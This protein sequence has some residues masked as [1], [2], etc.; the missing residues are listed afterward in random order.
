MRNLTLGGIA[1]ILLMSGCAL[2]QTSG[3]QWAGDDNVTFYL[4]FE[5]TTYAWKAAGNPYQFGSDFELVDGG[6]HG[7]A[8]RNTTRMGYLGYDG[9]DNIPLESGTVSLWLRSGSDNIFTDGEVHSVAVLCRTITGMVADRSLWPKQGLALSLRKTEANTLDLIAHVGGDEW[10]WDSKSVVLASCDASALDPAAWH[11]VAFS[12][13]FG[14][15]KSWLVINDQTIEG[16]FPE[17]V[18]RPHEYLALILG[19]SED[20]RAPAQQPLNGM[21]DEVA[22]LSVPWPEA[23]AIMASDASL[24]AARPEDPTWTAEA[25][26]FPDDPNL[27]RIE[28]VARQHLDMLVE[29]QRHGGWCLSIAW[30][31]KLQWTAKFRMP[32]PRNMIWLSK[33]AHTAFGAMHLLFAYEALGDETYLHAARN[34]AD[35]YVTTQDPDLGYW[36]HGYYYDNGEYVPDTQNPLIQDHCQTGPITLLAYMHRVTG[37][38]KYLDAL[39]RGADFLIVAQNDNG[40]WPHHY[41]V[42]SGIGETAQ[43]LPGGGEIND[44]GTSGP[45]TALLNVYEYTGEERYREA[46]LKGADWLME[47]FI[48][49]GKVAGWAGQY[50]ADNQPAAARHFEPPA[51]TQYGARWAANGLFAAYRETGDEKYLAP[52]ARVL[53]WFEQNKVMVDGEAAWWWDYD[54]ETGRPIRMYD[55]QIY[56]MDD[57]QQIA[58]YMRVTAASNP[59]QAKDSVNVP[60]LQNQYEDILAQPHGRVLDQPTQEELAEYVQAAAPNYVAGYI[61]GGSPPLNERVGLYTWDYQSGWRTNLSRHQVARFCDLLMRARAGRGDIAADNPLFRRIDPGVGWNKV[62]LDAS[63]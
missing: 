16:D 35:M 43:M 24:T 38:Q 62:L 44:Y 52:V 48:D 26:L 59:P 31:S 3:A 60:G 1:L 8:W 20:Y 30:P 9:L 51:V 18:E 21:L 23:Q 49:N 7:K 37:E 22:V 2:A 50:D 5:D 58:E 17:G 56:F 46:A 33:D 10:M 14:A 34:T 6:A 15:R 39:K 13:D 42:E 11:H 47:S 57:P 55:R 36:I 61:E 45:V 41:D 4:D 25:T 63:E 54:V 27:A 40:S 12:W 53:E 19:N 29:T 32:E 28:Q